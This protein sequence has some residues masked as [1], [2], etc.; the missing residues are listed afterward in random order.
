MVVVAALISFPCDQGHLPDGIGCLSSPPP[1]L[2]PF[3]A[4]DPVARE[5][6]QAAGDRGNRGRMQAQIL[7]NIFVSYARVVKNGA[8]S[9]LL[10]AA[11]RGV[12]EYAHQA[13][14]T[15]ARAAPSPTALPTSRARRAH[16]AR[17]TR[18]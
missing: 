3:A 12:A 6:A 2:P 13:S 18:R 16:C 4:L 15:S 10:P 11:L 14:A 17:L 9:P 1:L 8:H 5:L 7:E